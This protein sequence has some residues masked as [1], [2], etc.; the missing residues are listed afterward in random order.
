MTGCVFGPETEEHGEPAP[1][2][3]ET[4]TGLQ[5]QYGIWGRRMW[6][7]RSFRL[8]NFVVIGIAAVVMAAALRHTL[9]VYG[10]IPPEEI[11]WDALAAALI[12][13]SATVVIVKIRR[14]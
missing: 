10:G 11:R 13:V 7:P 4:T 1:V 5:L 9:H 3:E 2:P 6:D 8:R 12:A 14:R